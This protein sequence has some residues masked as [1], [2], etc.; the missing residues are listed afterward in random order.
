MGQRSVGSF[1]CLESE[2]PLLH[3]ENFPS[4]SQ[5]HTLAEREDTGVGRGG[6]VA[7]GWVT[8]KPWEK[9]KHEW[10]GGL[11]ELGDVGLDVLWLVLDVGQRWQERGPT[12]TLA[13]GA[14]CA[15]RTSLQYGIMC[16][17]RL[18]YDRK[19]LEK[20]REESQHEIKGK[21]VKLSRPPLKGWEQPGGSRPLPH[22]SLSWVSG[23]ERRRSVPQGS[24]KPEREDTAPGCVMRET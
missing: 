19:E 15:C 24:S 13:Q 16:L 14:R 20:R 3:L 6:E 10:A 18:N 7:S 11:F 22:C 4:I 8:C 21:L 17:K 5:T 23:G 2:G 12:E 1:Q 9:E